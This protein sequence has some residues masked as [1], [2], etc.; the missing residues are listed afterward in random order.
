[1]TVDPKCRKKLNLS[2]TL[3]TDKFNGGSNS[4]T[5]KTQAS[6]CGDTS[7]NDSQVLKK[8]NSK[9]LKSNNMSSSSL[10][11][12]EQ[13]QEVSSSQVSNHSCIIVEAEIHPPPRNLKVN[14]QH[15]ENEVHE[16]SEVSHGKE[17]QD[18]KT[19]VNVEVEKDSAKTD[20]IPKTTPAIVSTPKYA[21]DLHKL[22]RYRVLECDLSEDRQQMRLVLQPEFGN[23]PYVKRICMLRDLW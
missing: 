16:L 9:Q 4:S 5:V 19:C 15:Q 1:M 8:L 12:K 17:N 21:E 6:D 22:G 14:N 10:T 11:P 2:Q 13:F 23:Y 3:I 20:G 7:A 18:P